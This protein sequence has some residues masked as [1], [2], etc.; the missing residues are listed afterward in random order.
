MPKKKQKEAFDAPNSLDFLLHDLM[1]QIK[2]VSVENKD[3]P[4][5]KLIE[6][7]YKGIDLMEKLN[8]NKF[9]DSCPDVNFIEGVDE[10]KL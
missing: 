5:I 9:E 3:V 2:I 6:L 10:G 7:F 4:Y 8:G 1:E